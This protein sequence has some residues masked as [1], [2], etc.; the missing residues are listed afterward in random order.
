MDCL[1]G[2]GEGV[3]VFLLLEFDALAF[4]FQPGGGMTGALEGGDVANGLAQEFD[5][6]GAFGEGGEMEAQGVQ[7]LRGEPV[8]GNI[9]DG[10]A[11]GAGQFLGLGFHF[12]QQGF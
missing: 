12:G 9:G 11:G 1:L 5:A 7:V 2:G 6:F 10:T 3:A 8:G 4:Q